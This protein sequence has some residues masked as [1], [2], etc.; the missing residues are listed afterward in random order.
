MRSDA[1]VA[2]EAARRSA[3]TAGTA[4]PDALAHRQPSIRSVVQRVNSTEAGAGG[5][6]PDNRSH[7]RCELL[8]L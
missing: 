7:A 3:Q 5:D 1:I 4:Q 2:Q 6:A 8:S